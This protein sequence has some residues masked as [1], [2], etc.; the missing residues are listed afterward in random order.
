MNKLVS[1][2]IAADLWLK[3]KVNN[4]FRKEDGAVD[5]IAIVV[6]IAIAVVLA[7]V[8]KDRIKTLLDNLFNSAEKN[9]TDAAGK[10]QG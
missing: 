4:A 6:L 8:F 10:Y 9:A 3:D 2:Y 5:I 7:I 1:M